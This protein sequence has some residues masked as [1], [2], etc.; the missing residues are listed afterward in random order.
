[1]DLVGYLGVLR[2]RWLAILL[3]VIAGICGGYYTGHHGVKTYQATA[4]V[5]VN[6]P[7]AANVQDQLAGSQLS[8]NLVQTYA[9]MATSQVV[10]ERVVRDLGLSES[11]AAIASALSAAPV[12]NTYII[13]IS[14][15]DINPQQAQALAN[16]AANSLRDAV[17]SFDSNVSNRV[18]I[19]V[20]DLAALPTVPIS[21]R[22]RLDLIVGGILGVVAG[23]LIAA[24]LEALDRTMKSVQQGEA[25]I[26]VP[27]IG[28]VPRR[29]G[30]PLAVATGGAP[31]GE[32]YRAMRTAIR[33]LE[34]DKPLR[35]LLVTSPM[36]GDGKT[37]TAANLALALSQSGERV[38]VVDADLR[39]AQ[40]AE[41]FGLERAVGLTS[42][43]LGTAKLSETLQP[44]NE[45]L[46]L[47]ASGPLPPNPSEILVSQLFHTILQELHDLA[48]I[49][50]IDA[51]PVLPVTDA[52]A[53]AAQVD[54]VVMVVRHGSTLRQAAMEARRRLE[55]V[56]AKVVGYVFNAVPASES[57]DYYADYR[58]DYDSD[59]PRD[60]S[61]LPTI[62]EPRP[63][64]QSATTRQIPGRP[65]VG[66]AAAQATH[67]SHR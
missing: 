7:A 51:P 56:G 49:V 3:C 33:F 5:I 47:L 34:P 52:V 60:P 6:V 50:I 53:L 54:G 8:S 46:D 48:D 2:R 41:M 28:L 43:V 24:L 30:S 62:S 1:M 23:L 66:T 39:R 20:M 14:A 37:T 26:Q 58:Y 13:E 15:S 22:P 38:I 25:L 57:H 4:R 12:P 21:P 65:E 35:T 32:P 55:G 64:E 59:K 29:R 10:A 44:W 11:P 9:T 42:M 36:P 19:Q 40:L 18:T 67:P 31:E 17:A 61:T 27:L 63:A 16:S 45:Q